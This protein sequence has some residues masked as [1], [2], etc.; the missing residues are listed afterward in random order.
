MLTKSETRE[1]WVEKVGVRISRKAAWK[2]VQE[3]KPHYTLNTILP[4]S[5]FGPSLVYEK[6]G[7]PSTGAWP[8]ALYDGDL[9]M[10]AS[11]PPQ[12]F[13]DVRDTAKLHV[14]ALLDTETSN[15]RLWGFAET[16]N[17]NKVLAVFR[18]LWPQKKFSDDLEGLGVDESIVDTEAALKALRNV[19]GQEG[20]TGLETTMRDA[21]YDREGIEGAVKKLN[22]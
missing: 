15:E 21:G 19:F 5:N 3:E 10:I 2:Y 11:V 18:M 14:A 6:Q 17:W 7:H 1:Y 22:M 20:W 13:I 8:K 9:S 4:D 16:F 12:Y